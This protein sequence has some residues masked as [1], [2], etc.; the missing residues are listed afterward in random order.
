[1]PEVFSILAETRQTPVWNSFFEAP[2]HY[3]VA[4]DA[5]FRS[6]PYNLVHKD[7]RAGRQHFKFMILR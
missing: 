4:F 2:Q 1:M 6:V 3:L 7:R 5:N